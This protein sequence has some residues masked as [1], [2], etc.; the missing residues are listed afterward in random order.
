MG[1]GLSPCCGDYQG[2]CEVWISHAHALTPGCLPPCRTSGPSR[3]I[4]PPDVRRKLAELLLE[5]VDN[6]GKSQVDGG[7]TSG[8]A[9]V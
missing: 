1:L 4:H 8:G 7:A 3:L 2:V 6:G 9:E 5:A